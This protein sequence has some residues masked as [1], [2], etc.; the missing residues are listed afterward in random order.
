MH[1]PTIWVHTFYVKMVN[2][3]PSKIERH[4]QSKKPLTHFSS[5]CDPSEIPKYLTKKKALKLY[6]LIF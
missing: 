3:G 1:F 5:P 6:E 4:D 2:D